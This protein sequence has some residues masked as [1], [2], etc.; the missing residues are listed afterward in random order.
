M[1]ALESILV[2]RLDTVKDEADDNLFPRLALHAAFRPSA[3]SL[4]AELGPFAVDHIADVEHQAVQGTRKQDLVLVVGRLREEGKI[5]RLNFSPA[6]QAEN[7]RT[8]QIKRSVSR[9]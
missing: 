4:L 6:Y 2:G 7:G 3:F 8:I 1:Y 9:P 5:V